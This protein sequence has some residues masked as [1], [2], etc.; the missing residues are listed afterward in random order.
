[1]ALNKTTD[2]QFGIAFQSLI[3]IRKEPDHK[4]E[5]GTQLLFGEHYKLLEES[6]DGEWFLVE[7]AF[8]GYVGWM[9]SKQ[10]KSI[11]QAYFEVLESMCWP[12]SKDLIG[13]VHGQNKVIPIVYGSVMPIF[14]K[15]IMLVEKEACKYQGAVFFPVKVT[16]FD[17]LYNI[18]RFYVAAPYLWGGKSPFGIDCSGLVQQ[19]YR[20]CGYKLPR[21]AAQQGEMG[22]EVSL[23]ESRPGDLAFFKDAS[24]IVSH[25]G[26]VFPHKCILH[27]SGDVR[28]DKLDEKG[29]F[30]RDLQAYTHRFYSAKRIF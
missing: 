17:S 12:C 10:H 25:V 8:D 27:A 30:N 29:I 11:S 13:L 1:M 15:G 3:P 9:S 14:N 16:D 4:S 19:V 20:I 28:I 23:P 2:T 5:L 21:D 18:A 7:N 26:I 22:V 6:T 24:G